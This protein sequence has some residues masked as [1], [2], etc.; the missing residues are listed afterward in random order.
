MNYPARDFGITRGDSFEVI[1][2]KSKNKCVALH[3][4]VISAYDIG[5]KKDELECDN[6]KENGMKA[7]YEQEFCLSQEKRKQLFQAEKD[8]MRNASEGKAS[9]ERYR[10]AS[11]RIFESILEVRLCHMIFCIIIQ[12]NNLFEL[13]GPRK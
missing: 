5:A 1:K 7:S 3:L 6:Q 12:S 4:P 8:R 2:D 13:L 10:I 11:G 9:L